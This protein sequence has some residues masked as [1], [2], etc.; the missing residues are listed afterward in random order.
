[1][2]PQKVDKILE[3]LASSHNTLR[4]KKSNDLFRGREEKERRKEMKRG[5]KE[6]TSAESATTIFLGNSDDFGI[7]R[8]EC[9]VKTVMGRGPQHPDLTRLL[10][11]NRQRIICEAEDG[12]PNRRDGRRGN[13]L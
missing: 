2:L 11:Q 6:L 10:T 5:K 4:E 7:G 9:R 12:G 3:T 8:L 13:S 1:M